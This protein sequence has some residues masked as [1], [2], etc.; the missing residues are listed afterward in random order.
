MTL[1]QFIEI[2]NNDTEEPI[3]DVEKWDCG[4]LAQCFKNKGKSDK[5]KIDDELFYRYLEKKCKGKKEYTF[6]QTDK[7]GNITALN[8]NPLDPFDGDENEKVSQ[9]WH[10]II[11][12]LALLDWI[13]NNTKLIKEELAREYGEDKKEE[14]YDRFFKKYCFGKINNIEIEKKEQASRYFPRGY[15]LRI[16][17]E[18]DTQPRALGAGAMMDQI[19]KYEKM[20]SEIKEIANA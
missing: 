9:K 5:G 17:V 2:F 13:G 19:L 12:V 11:S 6:C 1:R 16:H 10:V 3:R 4:D 18:G 14:L 20:R 7:C 15:S 8:I